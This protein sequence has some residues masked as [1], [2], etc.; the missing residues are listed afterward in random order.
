MLAGPSKGIGQLGSP[1]EEGAAVVAL[2]I[3]LTFIIRSSTATHVGLFAVATAAG[4]LRLISALDVRTVERI[5]VTTG[6]TTMSTVG[7]L[8]ATFQGTSPSDRVDGFALVGRG[9]DLLARGKVFDT[10][11]HVASSLAAMEAT[12]EFFATG[13]AAA[14]V[15]LVARD[16]AHEIAVTSAGLVD[17]VEALGTLGVF[18]AVV[19]DW[20]ATRMVPITDLIAGR[21]LLETLDRREDY[22]VSTTATEFLIKVHEA[23]I[24]T[25]TCVAVALTAVLLAVEL[26][27]ALFRA[28]VGCLALALERTAACLA[29]VFLAGHLVVAEAIAK[30][31]KGLLFR[32]KGIVLIRK[33]LRMDDVAFEG[34][35]GSSTTARHKDLLFAGI[36]GAKM[37]LVGTAMDATALQDLAAHRIA[38]RNGIFARFSLTRSDREFATRTG[39]DQIE[40]SRTLGTLVGMALALTLVQAAG[41]VVLAD[42]VA[43]KVADPTLEE[44][45][46]VSR[47]LDSR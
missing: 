21:Q 5:R 18:V 29:T 27:V 23:T 12:N 32:M 33:R 26:V 14:D 38:R 43:V 17:H 35:L 41:E 16:V 1:V 2:E 4:S 37:A 15:L 13:T 7:S 25:S 42:R 30:Q 47:Q 6:M 46:L 45:L 9:P 3:D 39:L 8:D 11:T 36:T 40:T 10:R 31:F 19:A 24:S 20:M 34:L 28:L 22:C 44:L